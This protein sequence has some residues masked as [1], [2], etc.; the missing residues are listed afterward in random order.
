MR[1]GCWRAVRRML[2]GSAGD[3]GRMLGGPRPQHSPGGRTLE[4]GTSPAAACPMPRSCEP[5]AWPGVQP[6]SDGGAAAPGPSGA[7]RRGGE[8]GERLP[9]A[10]EVLGGEGG[11]QRGPVPLRPPQPPR[12]PLS[13]P[14]P[15]GMEEGALRQHIRR[16]RAEQAAVEA[17]LHAAPEPT[18]AGTHRGEDARARAERA[19]QDARALLPGW[20]RP[21]KAEL[22]RDLAMLKVGLGGEWGDPR[23]LGPS[24][25]LCGV[26]AGGDARREGA[27]L[28]GVCYGRA[29]VSPSRR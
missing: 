13:P 15:Q 23:C 22:L 26:R 7:G 6:H 14:A 29:S 8:R 12:R 4:G 17:S 3:A 11:S 10:A 16:L 20:R 24:P 19:L 5:G 28:G 18:H 1:K 21:G 9:W 2:G 25:A 27:E